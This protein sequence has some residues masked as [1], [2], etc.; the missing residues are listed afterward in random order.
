MKYGKPRPK[1]VKAARHGPMTA[2]VSGITRVHYTFS[3]APWLDICESITI[4]W[5]TIKKGHRMA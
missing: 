2:P 1:E 5:S 3:R 4:E